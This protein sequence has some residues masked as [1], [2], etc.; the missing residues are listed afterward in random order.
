MK[1]AI[2][3][4]NNLVHRSKHVVKDYDD[5]DDC[6]GLVLTI[7][8]NSLKKSYEKFDAD[9]C[10]ACFDSY[11]WRKDFYKDYK[12]QRKDS[13]DTPQKKEEHE[14][15]KKVLVDLKEFLQESTNVTVLEGK[16]IEADDFIGRWVQLH[17]DPVFKHIIISADGDY[18]QLVNDNVE[19]FDPINYTL[20]TMK[21]VFFQ[22]SR[23]KKIE[24]NTITYNGEEWKIKTDKKGDPIIFD[25]EWEL[26]FK[27]IRGDPSDNIKSAYPNV[28][29][30]KMLKAFE[31]RG[32]FDW[33]NF[34]ND[35]WGPDEDKKSVR[36]LYEN[37]KRL[38][39]LTDQ[40]T[41]IKESMDDIIEESIQKNNIVM[42]SMYFNEFCL[43]YRLENLRNSSKKIVAI[44]GSPYDA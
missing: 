23:K 4:V 38:I 2:I 37:N 6:V 44:L 15:I 42:V 34:M 19:L 25:P 33:N 5:F 11:S 36:E 35:T 14:I 43:K 20:Y 26:F 12:A 1:F 30:V 17:H 9:H 24:A 29:T 22:D 21:G 31:N 41:E 28:R 32:D 40:P 8:F 13:Y 3:D 10:V 27:C 16:G 7:V 39:D 18:K